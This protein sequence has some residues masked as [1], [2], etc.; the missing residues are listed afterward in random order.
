MFVVDC[1]VHGERWWQ[2]LLSGTVQDVISRMTGVCHRQTLLSPTRWHML[3]TLSC[4]QILYIM[5]SI[6][7]AA[8]HCKVKCCDF[9]VFACMSVTTQ[10]FK[11]PFTWYNLLSNNQLNVCIHFTTGCQTGTI[12]PVVKP[13]WQ[14]VVSC[15]QTFDRLSNPFDN[16]L[17]NRLYRV[18]SRLSNRLYSLVWQPVERTVAVRSTRLSN[19]LYNPVWQLVWQPAVSCKQTSNRLSNRHDN[20]LYTGLTTGCIV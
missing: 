16:H 9:Y 12:Q 5:C 4:W 19:R 20:Q 15:I 17:D 13:V 8:N 10:H 1:L 11:A 2:Q 14:P 3:M 7:H 18:Y 6:L